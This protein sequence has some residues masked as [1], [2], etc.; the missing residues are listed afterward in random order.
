M[1]ATFREREN[2]NIICS[3]NAAT[4]TKANIVYVLYTFVYL[5]KHSLQGDRHARHAETHNWM[6]EAK[7]EDFPL[8]RFHTSPD[9]DGS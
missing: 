5:S 1:T 2:Q 6:S 9:W 8:F 3:G 4:G 7:K